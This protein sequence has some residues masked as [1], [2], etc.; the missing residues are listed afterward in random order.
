MSKVL[1]NQQPGAGKLLYVCVLSANENTVQN[2]VHIWDGKLNKK[3]MLALIMVHHFDASTGNVHIREMTL[4][5][6]C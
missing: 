2:V 5:E 3:L 6:K 4:L 1:L